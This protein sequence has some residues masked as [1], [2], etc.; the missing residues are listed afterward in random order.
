MFFC[1]VIAFISFILFDPHTLILAFSRAILQEA[2]KNQVS[3]IDYETF[4]H[5]FKKNTAK[6]PHHFR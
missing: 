3:S 4:S 1:V 2:K 6:N 5:T